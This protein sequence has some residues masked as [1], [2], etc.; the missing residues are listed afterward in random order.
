MFMHYVVNISYVNVG[1]SSYSALNRMN[2]VE[3]GSVS[4][5]VPM[6][7][8]LARVLTMAISLRTKSKIDIP[9]LTPVAGDEL[10][11]SPSSTEPDPFIFLLEIWYNYLRI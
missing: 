9:L 10:L 7:I 11:A 1:R 6:A 2:R 5:V 8:A 4:L 3:K